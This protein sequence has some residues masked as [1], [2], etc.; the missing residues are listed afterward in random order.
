ME[1][2]YKAHTKLLTVHLEALFTH[3]VQPVGVK[4]LQLWNVTLK[5]EGESVF[6]FLG[7]V[8]I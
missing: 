3:F 6:V 7:H 4:I 2:V 5:V 1:Y 8:L